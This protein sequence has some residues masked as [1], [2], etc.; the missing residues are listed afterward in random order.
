MTEKDKLTLK[1]VAGVK[2]I[3]GLTNMELTTLGIDPYKVGYYGYPTV[4]ELIG[5][6]D[7]GTNED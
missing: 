1:I 5:N 4:S 3:E 7:G 2:S 6:M